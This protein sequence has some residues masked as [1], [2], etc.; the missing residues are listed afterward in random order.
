MADLERG[1]PV[2]SR[3]NFR[4]ASVSKQ[5]TATAIALLVERGDLRYDSPLTDIFPDFPEYGGDVTVEL[6]LTHTAGLVGY[7]DL[8]PQAMVAQLSDRDVLRMMHEADLDRISARVGL[9]LQ[10]YRI[11]RAGDDRRA[12]L[13]AILRPIPPRSCIRATGH[14]RGPWRTRP[15]SR[16]YPSEPMVTPSIGSHRIRQ[17]RCSRAIR[18]LPAPSSATA[19]C[20][21][22]STI[23]TN[24]IRL[25]IPRRSSLARP[26]KKCCNRPCTAMA[27]GSAIDEYKGR[28]R[29]HHSGSTRGFRTVM[30]RFPEQRFTVVILTNRSGPS[31]AP[32]GQ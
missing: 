30:Q 13:R 2:T 25:S 23:S 10:Q 6:L 4:L 1:T 3:T 8:M 14:E 5:F 22:L 17:N 29:A 28:L 27:S 9:P 11:R 31:V 20:I 18:A 12:S 26:S 15:A 16:K 7:T 24:G 32:L 21:R 19:A